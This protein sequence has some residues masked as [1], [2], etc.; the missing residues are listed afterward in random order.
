M[1]IDVRIEHITRREWYPF[2]HV[3][4]QL[5]KGASGARLCIGDIGRDGDGLSDRLCAMLAKAPHML[6]SH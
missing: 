4:E 6:G 2:R 5:C 1:Y 3:A